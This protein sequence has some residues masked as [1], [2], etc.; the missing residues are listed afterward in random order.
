[1]ANWLSLV[2]VDFEQQALLERLKAVGL[3]DD[4]PTFFTWLGVMPYLPR[5][6]FRNA[7]LDRTVARCRGGLRLWRAGRCV[8]AGT[9]RSLRSHDRKSCGCRRTLAEL[10]RSRRA[11]ERALCDRVRRNRRPITE[12]HCYPLLRRA[13]STEGCTRNSHYPCA[14]CPEFLNT[15]RRVTLRFLKIRASFRDLK[16]GSA[17]LRHVHT[18]TSHMIAP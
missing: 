4:R 15:R 3:N 12:G 2:T 5:E 17:S 11:R 1:L 14:A 9:P 10:L 7:F 16:F 6:R 18:W 13:R 8:S